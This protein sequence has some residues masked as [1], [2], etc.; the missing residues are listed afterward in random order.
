MD[1]QRKY[2]LC[3]AFL[4]LFSSVGFIAS[5]YILLTPMDDIYK[6]YFIQ[7]TSFLFYLL[8]SGDSA[9]SFFKAKHNINFGV[10]LLCIYTGLHN[11]A[12]TRLSNYF[13]TRHIQFIFI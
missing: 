7:V 9:A 6:S 4:S 11:Q 2:N 13:Y 10:N 12:K 3:A 8:E 5:W 1:N